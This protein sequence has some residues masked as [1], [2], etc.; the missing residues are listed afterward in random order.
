M[1][2][3]DRVQAGGCPVYPP[4][5]HSGFGG[6]VCDCGREIVNNIK[7]AYKVCLYTHVADTLV[8]LNRR[9]VGM[10]IASSR[11]RASLQEYCA[12]MHIGGCFRML[13]VGGEVENGKTGAGSFPAP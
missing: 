7:D 6:A 3:N 2:G 9:G 12:E 5:R 13:V 10:A 4:A 11:S 8:G 1:Q